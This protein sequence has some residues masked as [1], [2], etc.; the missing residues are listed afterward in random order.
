MGSP[1]S[2]IDLG[3]SPA[4]FAMTADGLHMA[5]ALGSV[6]IG[7]TIRCPK[8]RVGS[9][10]SSGTLENKGFAIVRPLGAARKGADRVHHGARADPE[11]AYARVASYR[12]ASL[13]NRLRFH[14]REARPPTGANLCTSMTTGQ[15]FRRHLR[16]DRSIDDQPSSSRSARSLSRPAARFA[17]RISSSP[18]TGA[19][20]SPKVAM[21]RF[22]HAAS[23]SSPVTLVMMSMRL[24]G[25]P[26]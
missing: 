7:L 16:T 15:S 20:T 8:G 14:P 24:G 1:A 18:R 12:A 2:G 17:F 10:P 6:Q 5:D 23:N 9:S 13:S 21:I 3:A 25:T 11:D 19:T 22:G 26:I 4:I